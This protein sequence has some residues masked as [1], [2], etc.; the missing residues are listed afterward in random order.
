MN[1]AEKNEIRGNFY[2]Q[3]NMSPSEL[4]HWLQ[5]KESKNV[6]QKTSDG[7]AIGHKSG[8]RIIE[9]KRMKK[10]EYSEKDYQHMQKVVGYIK[11]HLAQKPKDNPGNSNW[12]YSLMNW[13]HDPCKNINC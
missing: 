2:D 7:E 1:T 11:R 5:T 4:E 8:K 13:G 3:V 9:I 12:R 10:D 6:G